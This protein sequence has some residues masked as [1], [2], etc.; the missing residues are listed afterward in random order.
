[1]CA[2]MRVLVYLTDSGPGCL[3]KLSED[4][5]NWTHAALYINLPL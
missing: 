5:G 2:H 3:W 1:M 4:L